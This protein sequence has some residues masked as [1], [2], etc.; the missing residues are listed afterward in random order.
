MTLFTYQAARADGTMVRGQLEA[1]GA[2]HAAALLSRRGL[3]PVSV[4]QVSRPGS[5]KWRRPSA[6]AQ[7]TVLRSLASLVEAA[8][9]LQEALRVTR[10]LAPGVLEEPLARVEARVAEGAGLAAALAVESNLFSPVTIGLVGAGERGT[11]LGLALTQAAVQMER[12]AEMTARVRSAL[13][14]PLVLGT[15][16]VASVALIVFV[17]VPRFVGLLG[18][19]META[20]A[21]TKVLVAL[22]ATIRAHGLLLV[23][24]GVAGAGVA[25]RTGLCY[26]AQWH[27]WLLG[28]PVVGPIRHALASART[29]RTLGALL[30]AGTPAL[31]ALDVAR[32]TVGDDAVSARLVIARDRVAEGSSLSGALTALDVLTPSALQLAAVGDCAGRLPELLARAADLEEGL[33]ER[34][35]AGLIGLLEPALILTFAGVV[36]F[37]AAA[38]LQAIY[39]LRP[40]SW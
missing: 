30:E 36:A 13:T 1:T 6:R 16:G 11:G 26:R 23:A 20:P 12:R 7:A 34:R 19:A 10:R 27:R 35:L 5:W 22:S 17:I 14:Y 18:D 2:S 9:P 15:V 29:C 33:A 39:S 31:A 25:V 24:M 32:E 3:L 4:K 8:M 37:V 38:L 40:G 21:A 28:V